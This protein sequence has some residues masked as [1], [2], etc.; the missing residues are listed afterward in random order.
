MAEDL[1]LVTPSE[2]ARRAAPL[3]GWEEMSICSED[4]LSLPN[5]K[6]SGPKVSI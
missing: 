4:L 5:P 6:F 3:E 2:W 1:N